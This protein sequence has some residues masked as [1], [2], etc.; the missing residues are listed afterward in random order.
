MSAGR[1]A[2]G[3]A[4]VGSWR[5]VEADVW[6]RAYLDLAGP[7][8]LHVGGDGRV[9]FGFGALEATGA[10]EY[11]RTIVFFR[12]GGFDEGDEISGDGSAELQDDGS[13]EIVLDWDN[14]DDAV[15]K[16]RRA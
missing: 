8:Y 11:A 15:L 10:L 3:C 13:V 5:I 4:L 7:A 9:A 16:A 14:G 1:D 2:A 6:D 12:W